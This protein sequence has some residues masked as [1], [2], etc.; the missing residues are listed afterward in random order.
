MIAA[1]WW[2]F[3]CV[4]IG[5]QQRSP[6]LVHCEN[7]STQDGRG[8][9]DGSS[10]LLE[11]SRHPKQRISLFSS[12]L[13]A[14][15]KQGQGENH[16]AGR[17]IVPALGRCEIMEVKLQICSILPLAAIVMCFHESSSL[18]MS[19][20]N[21]QTKSQCILDVMNLVSPLMGES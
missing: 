19:K 6:R 14:H 3:S 4:Q 7:R 9:H 17:A 11:T 18:C 10:W 1:L 21:A 5:E 2:S 15:I 16:R 12:A 13:E 20:R 8:G